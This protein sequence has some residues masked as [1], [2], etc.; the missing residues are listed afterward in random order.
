MNNY[1]IITPAHNEQAFIEQTAKSIVSQTVRPTKWVVVDDGS[2]DH[3]A[4]IVQRYASRFPFVQL[5]RQPHHSERNFARKVMAFNRGLAEVQGLCFEFLGNVDADIS[6]DADYFANILAAFESDPEL[7]LSG[8][9]VYTRFTRT[10][11]TYDTTIDSVGGKVQLFRRQ[12]FDDIG[13][14]RPLQ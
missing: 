11:V 6:F 14:D 3:T 9:I 2:T 5:I 8:G 4:D 10:F 13:G 1:V 7:G 12:C